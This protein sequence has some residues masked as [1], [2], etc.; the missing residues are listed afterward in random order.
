VLDERYRA[1]RAVRELLERLA[2]TGRL[3][4]VLDDVHW[5]DPASIEL[6]SGLLRRPPQAMVLLALALR[7]RQALSRL[8]AALEQA[9]RAGALDRLELQ[10]LSEAEAEE[11]LG[12]SLHPRAARAVYEDSGGTALLHLDSP[13]HAQVAPT[14]SGSDRQGEVVEGHG[15][16]LAS[17]HLHRQLVVAAAEVLYERMTGNDDPGAV[18]L[19][20]SS[21]RVAAVPSGGR[22]RPRLGCWRTARC[23]PMPLGASRP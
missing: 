18:V 7:P 8:A 4:L 15:Q 9:V 16:P 11:L 21:H 23:G 10:V 3:A 6:L 13:G 19:L 17:R 5:A 22:G 14:S 12:R 20:E 2:A 1:H